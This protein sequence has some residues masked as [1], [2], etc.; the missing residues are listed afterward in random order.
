M[1][2]K[3]RFFPLLRSF[4]SAKGCTVTRTSEQSLLKV[5]LSEQL[6]DLPKQEHTVSLKVHVYKVNNP[7]PPVKVMSGDCSAELGKE[8]KSMHGID[9]EYHEHDGIT[10]KVN[11]G[12]SFLLKFEK[13]VYVDDV[14]GIDIK[15]ATSVKT[16]AFKT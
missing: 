2:S 10:V 6:R 14:Y 11:S 4:S 8:R 9:T 15:P 12:A 5:D 1:Q 7:V 13:D 16:A 3:F